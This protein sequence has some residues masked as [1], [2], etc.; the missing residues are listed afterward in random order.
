MKLEKHS[1][2]SMVGIIIA[3]FVFL[4]VMFYADKMPHPLAY[5]S[6]PTTTSIYKMTYNITPTTESFMPHIFDH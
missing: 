4:I 3:A 5:H 6:T 1:D 2:L